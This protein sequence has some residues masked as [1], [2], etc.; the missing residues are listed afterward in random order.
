MLSLAITLYHYLL[1]IHLPLS[2]GHILMVFGSSF[3]MVC[4][5][6]IR[7]ILFVVPPGFLFPT[8]RCHFFQMQP[9]SLFLVHFL[10]FSFYCFFLNIHSVGFE[11]TIL[12]WLNMY[13]YLKA[14]FMLNTLGL[15]CGLFQEVLL[16]VRGLL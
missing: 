16:V 10:C 15:P 8:D 7:K 3:V 4:Q 13:I 1:G 11:L 14:G 5:F 9:C 2:D 12:L 6:H